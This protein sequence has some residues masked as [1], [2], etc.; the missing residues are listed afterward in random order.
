MNDSV[1]RAILKRH[2]KEKRWIALVLCLSML[3]SLG[4]FTSL[5]MR[6]EART[7]TRR[8]LDCPYALD[9]AEPVAHIHN[10]DCCDE[11]GNLVCTLPEILPHEHTEACFARERGELICGL[12]EYAG[13]V[14]NENCYESY[15]VN[16]CGLEESE[17]HVHSDECLTRVQDELICENTDPEHEH[18]DECYTWRDELIC[19]L[20]EGQG[21][22]IH[23][24]VDVLKMVMDNIMEGIMYYLGKRA[25]GK[26]KLRCIM[27]SNQFSLLADSAASVIS[28][29]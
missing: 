23:D 17:G 1:L 22:H 24:D 9:D 5:R 6:G 29:R 13:H 20:E 28:N 8:V 2:K 18:S 27:Y 10:E 25:D 4:T 12:E 11:A 3:V 7:Y 15:P 19:G 16:L 14:H 21:A 26:L